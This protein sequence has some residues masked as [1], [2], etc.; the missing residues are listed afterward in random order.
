[1]QM[2]SSTCDGG[3]SWTTRLEQ[4]VSPGSH[5]GPNWVKGYSAA[6]IGYNDHRHRVMRTILTRT[7]GT[8]SLSRSAVML[9]DTRHANDATRA[10]SEVL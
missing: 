1:M 8:A 9:L 2:Q 4:S 5:Y 10:A 3:M 7:I 6:R